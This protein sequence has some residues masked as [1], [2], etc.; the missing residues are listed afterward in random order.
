M[1]RSF[2][3]LDQVVAAEPES[4]KPIFSHLS[5]MLKS[6]QVAF[7]AHLTNKEFIFNKVQVQLTSQADRTLAVESWTERAEKHGGHKGASR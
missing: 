2:E 7:D 3:E 4:L 5:G 6:T 1:A